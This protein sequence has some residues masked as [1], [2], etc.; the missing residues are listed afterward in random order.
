[1]R[2]ASAPGARRG[3]LIVPLA[4]T[5]VGVALLV[6][7]GTWQLQRKGEKDALV[8]SLQARLAEPAKFPAP[9]TWPELKL[10]DAEYRRVTFLAEFV[11]GEEALVHSAGSAFRPDVSGPGYWVFSPARLPGGSV[12]VVNR[13]FVPE[14]RQDPASRA[15]GQLTGLIDITGAMR[16]PE[17]RNAFTPAD[18]PKAN[19][20]FARDHL[21]MAEAK[22]WGT[23]APFYVE[24]E[25]P[26][27]PGG[28]PRPGRLEPS[29]PNNH[30][31][32][33]IT[34]YALALALLTIFAVW[35]RGRRRAAHVEPDEAAV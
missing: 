25:A 15:G 19:L 10:E 27:P 17:A 7:L 4:I 31:Q 2:L 9:Q 8:A 30:L 35:A 16:W 1:M 3:G 11:P 24:Q 32:Y 29:L 34:W 14:G 18:S 12:L 33:A 6:G 20:W 26:V 28:L 5:L 22:S 21:A 23:V 13:G